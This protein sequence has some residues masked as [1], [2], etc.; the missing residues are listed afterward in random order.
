MSKSKCCANCIYYPKDK[1]GETGCLVSGKCILCHT[2]P[3]IEENGLFLKLMES[4][5]AKEYISNLITQTRLSTIEE[6]KGMLETLSRKNGDRIIHAG[7][8]EKI[9]KDTEYNLAVDQMLENLNKM[10]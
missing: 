5:Q 10:K 2:P 6:A 3:K 1:P 7:N 8:V 9:F 4:D